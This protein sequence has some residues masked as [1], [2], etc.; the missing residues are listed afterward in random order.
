MSY[1]K[2]IYINLKHRK[3][4]D[5]SS[6]FCV[7]TFEVEYYIITLVFAKEIIIKVG[8]R[9]MKNYED[10]IEKLEKYG[11]NHIVKIMEKMTEEEK[12][13]LAE[14]LKPIMA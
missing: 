7:F 13:K 2:L 9:I 14:A 6:F 3:K 5:F 12:D 1:T 10:T 4:L 11:Q 8:V